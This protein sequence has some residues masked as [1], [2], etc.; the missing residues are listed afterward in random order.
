MQK[1]PPSDYIPM[2]MCKVLED[3]Y[4]V[5][6][7]YPSFD[8][9]HA[10]LSD[11]ERIGVWYEAAQRFREEQ[12]WRILQIRPGWSGLLKPESAFAV[13]IAFAQ[14]L[15]NAEV[16]ERVINP[17]FGRDTCSVWSHVSPDHSFPCASVLF[18]EG[19]VMGI[20]V[21]TQ[22]S[23]PRCIPLLYAVKVEEQVFSFLGEQGN[24]LTY[25]ILHSS[26]SKPWD[27]YT[28]EGIEGRLLDEFA[29]ASSV[30]LCE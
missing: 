5:Q 2:Y 13:T 12:A 16:E 8:R 26:S 20:D 28:F 21:K 25:T 3:L 23:E 19:Q 1:V 24:S 6:V 7:P 29:P 4:R 14:F 30:A 11:Y 9:K 17:A 22:Q 18:N 27:F 10:T 15:Y